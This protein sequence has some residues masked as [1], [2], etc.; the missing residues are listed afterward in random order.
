MDQDIQNLNF[1][2]R[3]SLCLSGYKLDE[4][5]GPQSGWEITVTNSTG[6]EVGTDTTDVNGFWEVCDLIQGEYNISETM[7]PGWIAVTPATGTLPVTLVDKNLQ[8]LNFTNRRS[9]CLSGYKLDENNGPQ[10]GW[11]IT[12]TNSTGDAVGTDTTDVNG[13]WEVCD[14]VQ[15]D[16]NVSETLQPGWVAVTPVSGYQVVTL[17]DQNVGNV[18]FTNKLIPK[19]GNITGKKGDQK[20]PECGLMGWQITLYN[21]TTG[22]IYATDITGADGTYEFLNVP[23]GTYWLNE[24]LILGWKQ[25][26]PNVLVTLDADHPDF[27]YN[28]INAKDETCCI[29]PP[30]ASFTYIKNGQEVQF[31]DTST[32]PKA[33]RYIWL[34]GDGTMSSKPDPVKIFRMPGT[35]TVKLY[36]TWA[37]CDGVTY[38][39]KSTSQRIRVP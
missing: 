17:V 36:I 13:Y 26:T 25:I 33:V 31:T 14:L 34:F 19:Y 32:G 18:N 23:Y 24:T 16:Y 21:A 29:C 11:E 2:N 10:E 28:F 6:D 3:R 37:D 35:Y 5:N 12:V 20:C 1:T 22:A 4:N 8:N 27:E 9:L 30:T 15:G 7:Q 39:W 38:T